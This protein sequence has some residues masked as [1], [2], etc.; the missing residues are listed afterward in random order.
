ME[1]Q[2]S[3]QGRWVLTFQLCHSAASNPRPMRC[4]RGQLIF[5]ETS[6]S[7]SQH[8]ES[9]LSPPLSYLHPSSKSINL[10]IAE[11]SLFIY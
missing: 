7:F 2:W 8:W 10:N 4:V 1:L 9:T 6:Q 3:Y 5:A 11:G